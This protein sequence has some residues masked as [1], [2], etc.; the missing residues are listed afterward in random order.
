[1]HFPC[2]NVVFNTTYDNIF[3]VIRKAHYV[4]FENSQLLP[5]TAL[6]FWLAFIAF[7]Y[8]LLF[9]SVLWMIWKDD[10]LLLFR[11]G[12]FEIIT[13]FCCFALDDMD[14][15][16]ELRDFYLLSASFL[17]NSSFF[18][19]FCTQNI[20]FLTFHMLDS[21]FFLLFI[22]V[23]PLCGRWISFFLLFVCLILLFSCFLSL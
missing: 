14:L 13:F 12:W 22:S 20:F 15:A 5:V 7:F 16:Y 9:T 19:L 17:M 4:F 21:S 11:L 18:P 3:I 23:V 6:S 8:R 2:I 10:F 1:M